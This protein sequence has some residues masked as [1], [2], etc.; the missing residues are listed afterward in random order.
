MA[1]TSGGKRGCQGRNA[2]AFTAGASIARFTGQSIPR[3]SGCLV[4]VHNRTCA[5]DMPPQRGGLSVLSAAGTDEAAPNSRRG[6]IRGTSPIMHPL[7]AS[8]RTTEAFSMAIW[9]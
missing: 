1:K 8:R 7:E 6:H 4:W 9:K 3:L 5:T 2:L